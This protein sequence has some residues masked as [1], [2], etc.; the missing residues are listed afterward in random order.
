MSEFEDTDVGSVYCTR[1]RE[2]ITHH[3]RA[4]FNDGTGLIRLCSPCF[5]AVYDLEAA[6]GLHHVGVRYV[7][8][9]ERTFS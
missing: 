5:Q 4:V 8:E 2:D 7:I 9:L 6:L 3:C 1:C